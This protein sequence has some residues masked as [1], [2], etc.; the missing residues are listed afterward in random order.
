MLDIT[1]GFIKS[2]MG[3]MGRG[4]KSKRSKNGDRKSEKSNKFP[5]KSLHNVTFPSQSHLEH[6]FFFFL[7]IILQE[8][9]V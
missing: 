8:G 1:N 3:G 2:G 9:L 7:Q 6:G 5:K 4:K